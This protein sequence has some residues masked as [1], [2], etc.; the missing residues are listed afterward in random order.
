MSPKGKMGGVTRESQTEQT[1][2][3]RLADRNERV[4]ITGAVEAESQNIEKQDA[5]Q[6]ETSQDID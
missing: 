2:R 1:I 6:C 3:L 5:A 4:E